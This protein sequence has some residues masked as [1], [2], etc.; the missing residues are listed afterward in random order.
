MPDVVTL[1]QIRE[2]VKTENLKPS[3]LFG[4]EAL[5]ADPVIVAHVKQQTTG[6][7]LHRKR[8][9]TDL[10][11]E[12]RQHGE[13]LKAKD[14]EITRLKV[15]AVKAQVPVLFAKQKD[16]RKLD[17]KQTKY[18]NMRLPKFVPT[19][20]EDVDKEFNAYL[21]SEIEE[22]NRIAKELGIE[23]P[24]GGDKGKTGETGGEA[25]HNDGGGTGEDKYVNPATNPMI[26]PV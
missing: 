15:E 4:T 24:A 7:Y 22:Y 19:K 14:A 21:D 5:V 10:E 2:L 16:A 9:E 6:E 12:K 17:E 20:P 13:A 26:K 25:G 1:D 8:T 11:E 23:T 18:V 3:D